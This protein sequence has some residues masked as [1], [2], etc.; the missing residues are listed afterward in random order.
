M[1]YSDIPADTLS[2]MSMEV[3]VN[4]K[5]H[6]WHDTDLPVE[7]WLC[8]V[9]SEIFEAMEADRMDR[10]A[11]LDAFVESETAHPSFVERFEGYIKDTFEDELAD[12]AIRLLDFA[13]TLDLNFRPSNY[14]K[15]PFALPDVPFTVIAFSFIRTICRKPL[16]PTVLQYRFT[17]ELLT[18]DALSFLFLLSEKYGFDL[19]D[20]IRM[21]M[22]YNSTRPYKHGGKKY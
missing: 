16:N 5:N 1:R 2:S 17:I 9:I 6:G 14:Q 4:A 11:N 7:H 22:A 20:H 10:H 19:M 18:N 21:K 3:Y 13:A 15:D 12:V 8:L